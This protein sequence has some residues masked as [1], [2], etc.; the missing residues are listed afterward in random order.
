MIRDLATQTD[1]SAW[2]I[3]SMFFFIAVFGVVAFRV[4]S[5]KKGAFDRQARLPLDDGTEPLESSGPER[6]GPGE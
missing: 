2:V 1:A 3:A 4:L 6:P 5:S